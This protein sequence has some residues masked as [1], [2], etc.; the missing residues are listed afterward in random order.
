MIKKIF[1]SLSG[2]GR[3]SVALLMLAL[4]HQMSFAQAACAC[5]QSVQISLNG[6]GVA[7]VTA[8]ML[9]TDA[10]TCPGAS[11]LTV[12]VMLTPTGSP[13]VGNPNVNCDHI[14]KTLYG[15][16]SNGGNSC[17][18]LLHVED[19]IAP[20]ISCPSLFPV[21]C[22][23]MENFTPG[24]TDNCGPAGVTLSVI[25]EVVTVNGAGCPLGTEVLKQ[26]VRTYSATDASGNISAP[27]TTTLNVLRI[28]SLNAIVKPVDRTVQAGNAIQCDDNYAKIPVGEPYAG[29]PSPVAINGAY[30][31]GVPTINGVDLYPNP[32]THCNLVVSFTDV[33]LPPIKCVT[34]VMRTWQI[35]EWSCD[36]RTLPSLPPQIIEIVDTK[37]P[38]VTA[39]SAL[40][41]TTGN[42]SCNSNVPFPLPTVSD[43]CSLPSEI[44]VDIAY[45]GGFVKHGDPRFGLLPVGVH[46][47]TYTVYDAC[48]NSTTSTAT[49]TVE[50]N[51][52]PVSVCDEFTTVG[53]TVDGNAWVPAT[54]F[55]DG[56]YDECGLAKM[57][58]KRMNNSNCLP[59]S[60]PEFPGFTLL[61]ETGSGLTKKYYYLSNH[62]ATPKVALKTAKAMEGYAVSFETSAER[63]QIRTWMKAYNPGLDY[64]IGYT[65]LKKE[66][67]FV[68]ESGA[69][70]VMTV[71]GNSADEDYVFVDADSDPSIDGQ[72]VAVDGAEEFRYVVEITGSCGFSAYTQFCCSDIGT[73]QMVAFRVIDKSGNWNDCMVSAVVQDKIPPAITCPAH[74]TVNC[75]TDFNVLDLAAS[76][77][78]A[79][80]SD[81]CE[82]PVVT[83]IS[84]ISGYTTCR[85]GIISRIFTVT[86]AG[87]RTATCSQTITFVNPGFYP[88]PTLAEWPADPAPI[89]GCLDPNDPR[90]SPAVLGRPILNSGA[91]DL[92][93]A[94]YKDQVFPFNNNNGEACFKILRHWS[95]IDWCQ[96]LFVNGGFKYAQ[97]NHTQIIKVVD[98]VAPVITSSCARVSTCTFDDTCQ[99]GFIALSATATDVC[100]DV[101]GWSYKIDAFND[102]TFEPGLSASGFGNSINANGTYPIGSHRIVWS[103]EDKCGNITTCDQLFD[104]VNC[105]A[106]SPVL[107]NGLAADLMPID[108]NNDGIPDEGMLDIWAIDFDNK[109]S[110]PCYTDLIFSFAPITL[111]INGNPVIQASENYDCSTRG[112]QDVTIYVGVLTPMGTLIQSFATTFIDIQDNNNA[113]TNSGNGRLVHIKGIL[114]TE[115]DENLEN[116]SVRLMGSEFNVITGQTGAFNFGDMPVGGNYSVNPSKNDDHMNGLSTLDLVMIQRH[117]LNIEELNS[118]YKLIAADVTKDKKITAAD[119]VELRKLILGTTTQF[120]NNNSWRFVDRNFV[121]N[122]VNN[123]H[124]EA[125]PEIY[126][127]AQ[128]NNDMDVNF[129]AVKVGDVN[130]NAQANLLNSITESRTNSKLTL[131]TEN[132]SFDAGSVIYVPV[133]V[134]QDAHITGFQFTLSFDNDVFEMISVEGNDLNLNENNFGFTALSEGLISCSWNNSDAVSLRKGNELMVVGLK[135]LKNGNLNT[136]FYIGSDITKAEAYSHDLQTMNVGFRIKGSEKNTSFALYQNIPN[137]FKDLTQIGF[138]IPEAMDANLTVYDVTGKVIITR[139]LKA[140]KG[141]NVIELNKNELTSTGVLYYT[142]KAGT[143]NSTKKM[144]ILE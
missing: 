27:C 134:D 24:V 102:G 132:I 122:D 49:V 100:T 93:G 36:N 33:K 104:I 125:F 107:L 30:G 78:N 40:T 44:K 81:N 87:G 72:L 109:S 137:P 29:N 47:I 45:P 133:K 67:T 95:V 31:S 69:T 61:G 84:D 65:D 90:F 103:F 73:N 98:R 75:E 16:V 76:F 116:A 130:G 141:Y 89:D 140:E 110:H 12:T 123:A 54:V 21:S 14:G 126:D 20:V 46:T 37:G 71:N 70:N 88:G 118:P 18:S 111:D 4:G 39:V 35:I 5:K 131:A 62:T 59:C 144:I 112:R 80:G 55:D 10:A 121:F 13:I 68:W 66:G 34:K 19:K 53:L 119:L 60:T 2:L 94:D 7:T 38:I 15:K 79:V 50:D 138:E 91:C 1:T 82:N 6:N 25:G 139:S 136:H 74:L 22:S 51:T 8:A 85:T 57:L 23:E 9:L 48:H 43:N 92:V 142:L 101:L 106:P 56:S 17:W 99:E 77:G 128:L 28:P 143:F 135:A 52:A 114:S 105:K 32:S 63:T 108:T 127:I 86:D 83:E 129:V 11:D 113:C 117:I 58:V 26:F 120:S 42:H 3:L 97:W 41:A 115:S 64:L 124:T 96:P